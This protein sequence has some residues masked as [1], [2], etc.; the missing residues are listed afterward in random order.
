MDGRLVPTLGGVATLMFVHRVLAAAVLLLVI[1]VA[2]RARTMTNRSK[3]LAILSSV[4]LLLYVAQI[5]VGA[6][7]V[8]SRLSSASVTGAR[9]PVGVDL[10]RPRRDRHGEPPVRG[11]RPG[12]RGGR[13]ALERETL[14]PARDDRRL[15]QA[16]EAA[17][18]RPAADHDRAGDGR[19]PSAGC[20]RSA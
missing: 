10:G 16:H 1:W 19:S 11:S 12:R 17:D 4:T 3:D 15:L 6:A 18:H 14:E 20:R 9:R 7:N 8:W 2:I 13:R 5:L